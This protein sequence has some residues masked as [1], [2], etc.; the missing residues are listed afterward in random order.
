MKIT[1]KNETNIA[2]DRVDSEWDKFVELAYSDGSYIGKSTGVGTLTL[3]LLETSSL[4]LSSTMKGGINKA[5]GSISGYRLDKNPWDEGRGPGGFYFI[6][7]HL[8]NPGLQKLFES[9]KDIK[10]ILQ[11]TN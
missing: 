6:N 4:R 3:E 7:G 1:I 8:N 5:R 2:I 9:K 10:I 11:S